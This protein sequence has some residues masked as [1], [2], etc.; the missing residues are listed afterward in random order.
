MFDDRAVESDAKV[1]SASSLNFSDINSFQATGTPLQFDSNKSQGYARDAALSGT[2]TLAPKQDNIQALD[3]AVPSLWQE[4]VNPSAAEYRNRWVHDI[5][6]NG[7]YSVEPGDSLASIAR[8]SLGVSGHADA[9]AK[10]VA[11][12]MKRI[13]ALN[14]L[15]VDQKGHLVHHLKAGTVLDV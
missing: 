7:T 5:L 10:E 1:S 15:P 13:A 11:H 3:M 8:R 12:E 2:E 4:H 14:D 9:S 6:E